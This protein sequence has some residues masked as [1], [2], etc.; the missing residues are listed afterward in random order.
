[1]SCPW[2]R[3]EDEFV[4]RLIICAAMLSWRLKRNY[5]ELIQPWITQIQAF[6]SID[7]EGKVWKY[8]LTL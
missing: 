8:C 6:P 3:F 5:T 7:I 4:T 1:M 2:T